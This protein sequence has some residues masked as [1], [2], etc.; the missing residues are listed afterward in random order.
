MTPRGKEQ[1]SCALHIAALCALAIAQP[2]Y[3]LIGRHAEFLV[4][5]G[6]SAATVLGL[7][8]AL[9]AGVPLALVLLVEA[10]RLISVRAAAWFQAGII[11]LLAAL[12]ASIALRG[13]GVALAACGSG[14]AGV[15]AV[16]AYRAPEVRLFLAILSP[17]ALIFPMLFVT[18]TP[19]G[20]L[21]W[22]ASYS[23][24]SEGPANRPPVV[25]VVLDEMGA[26]PILGPDG[27]IDAARFP[28]LARL[29]R[30]S[31]WFPNAAGADPFT[32]RALPAIVTG[33]APGAL[34]DRL[35]LAADHPENLFTW[36]AGWYEMRVM[37]SLSRLCPREICPETRAR[38]PAALA[39]DL[40]VLYG[41]LVLPEGAARKYLPPLGMAWAGFAGGDGGTPEP[42]DGLKVF[43]TGLTR[44]RIGMFRQ[45]TS[46]VAGPPRPVFYF[47]H[48]LL[49]HAPYRYRASGM[50][51]TPDKVAPDGLSPE[52]RWPD[53][54]FV[55][56][57][58][59]E[60][61][62]EQARF[63]DT[64]LGELLDRLER[65]RL[66]D[67]A[68]LVVTSDHGV[69]FAPGDAHRL[70]T[71]TNYVDI[72][73]VPLL[74]KRPGQ[75]SSEIND[76]P[77][78]GI[79]IGPTIADA[80][81]TALP[82]T[83]DG[84]S[85]LAASFPERPTLSYPG[86]DLPAMPRFHT[87]AEARRRAAQ[88]LPGAQYRS[89][90]GRPVSAF[91]RAPALPHQRVLSR[92]FEELEDVRPETGYVPSFVHGQVEG[93]GSDPL[94][95]ALAVDGTI[96]YVTRT[97]A[98]M[99]A[100]HRLGALLPEA[101]V[102]RGQHTLEIFVVEGADGSW[103]LAPLSAELTAGLRLESDGQG[104]HFVTASGRRVP[105]AA[106]I[107]GYVDRIE[108]VAGDVVLHGW[109]TGPDG[110]STAGSIVA[111]ADGRSV[112]VSA[113]DAERPDVTAARAL[114]PGVRV[115][116]ALTIP[117][118]HVESGPVRLFALGD[119][120]AAPIQIPPH[121]IAQLTAF[122]R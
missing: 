16:L 89:L 53:D 52:G 109:A 114:P 18:T 113:P 100:S 88:E 51:Y 46:T 30:T 57:T 110:R 87:R 73:A 101:S 91:P 72:A 82:W 24:A 79:D 40:L 32:A 43:Q 106:G 67:D 48:A 93:A 65:E 35:P 119:D 64:L 112:A 55:V 71:S 120:S 45:F 111:V 95:L 66:F 97:F 75:T 1:L 86:Y 74:I 122:Q 54:S 92:Q 13:H 44:G 78:S 25:M 70:P 84:T 121:I 21:L 15:A 42:W 102:G 34:H 29:A 12:L 4:A 80:L 108:I 26:L 98:W 90:V 76:R 14:A 5:H 56:E 22:P 8:A 11:G 96:Q 17:A 27:T 19:A 104:E 116:F 38:S 69:A 23:R 77:V 37:E 62:L 83:H 103:R 2:L 20:R 105:T 118:E 3:D 31:T 50:A 63:A 10:A 81:G 9:S 60:R 36:L 61:H 7:V 49:P 85:V 39:Q 99:G 94:L 68:L 115:T 117:H 41:Y 33:R 59:R 6:A 28:H 58:A 107:A 47:V